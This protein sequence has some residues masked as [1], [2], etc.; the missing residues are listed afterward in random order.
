MHTRTLPD[1]TL[2]PIL[3][4]GTWR[5]GE[6]R[7]AHQDE[8]AALRLGIELGMTLI[9]TAEMYGE[10]AA[11]LVV[12]DAIRGQRDQVYLVSKVYPQNATQG[13]TRTACQRSLKRLGTDRIDLYLLHW[14]GGSRLEPFVIAAQRLREQGLIGAWGVSNFDVDD[15]QDLDA[16]PGGEHCAT[17]QV[18]WNLNARGVEYDL[19]PWLEARSMPMMAYSPVGQG[20]SL[21]RH[22]ALVAVASRLGATPAQ[23]ALAFVLSRK[24]VVAIPKAA[25]QAHVRQNREA[26][27]LTLG[28]G[29]L[30]ALEAAFPKPQVKRPL[31]ML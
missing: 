11:E 23:V 16:V 31:E 18:L 24:G 15:M 10:G 30:A 5:M 7:S 13:G 20:G 2:I 21:L 12:A 3:G 25:S 6:D 1:G 9:D 22:P 19:L 8:V 17:N 28:E 26:L 29:E 4:Q 27:D 14:R